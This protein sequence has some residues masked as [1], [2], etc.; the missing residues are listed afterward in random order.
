MNNL[1]IL[2]AP[3]DEEGEASEQVLNAVRNGGISE[4]N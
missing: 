2:S 4:F 3:E 1:Q